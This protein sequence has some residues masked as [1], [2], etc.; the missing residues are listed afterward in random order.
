MMHRP[1]SF[2]RMIGN[3]VER[4]GTLMLF[5]VTVFM[6]ILAQGNLGYL[7]VLLSVPAI[8]AGT[9]ILGR[10]LEKIQSLARDPATGLLQRAGIVAALDG[11][12]LR[13]AL[14]R[15][16]TAVIV[17]EMCDFKAVEERH[18]RAAIEGVFATLGGRLA[19]VLRSTDSVA[20]LDG[21]VFAVALSSVR[22]LD[23]EV[24]I[25][26][27]TRLQQAVSQPIPLGSGNLYMTASVGFCLA[28][29]LDL[30]TGE[31]LLQAATT[32]MIEAER[33]GPGAI[34]G[35]S[36]AMRKRIVSRNSLAAQVSRALD[37]GEIRA[38]FQPQVSTQDG[39]LTGFEALARWEHPDRGFIPP[40][41]F[42]P[43]LEQAGLM[44]RLGEQMVDQSLKALQHWDKIG[45][46]VPQVAVNFS[47]E[48]LQNPLLVDW[49]RAELDR[50]N[51]SPERLTIEVLE[52]VVAGRAEN[53]VVRNL[54][55][56]SEL[57]C[58]L[59]LDDFGTGHA[60]ITNIR[61]FSIARIKIDR[62]FVT[63]IDE[64]PDQQMMF[65]AILT[66]A[67]RLGLDTLAEGVE[68][69]SELAM[70]QDLGCQHV[71]GFGIARPMPLDE[72]DRWLKDRA[73]V[74]NTVTV[75]PR[76]TG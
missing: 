16:T 62:S 73:P 43:A 54:A 59:D 24:A 13:S 74:P 47:T 42:L 20:R 61:R 60:S 55:G 17:L 37:K 44:E 39:R 5:G 18:D 63:R 14:G 7:G 9:R 8:W 53:Q 71:Q 22:R 31:K 51:M 58:T 19:S 57:G 68:N 52:T 28:T 30:P 35:Y 1:V 36:E 4:I 50:Y 67:D 76:R 48:E 11:A 10:R 33:G 27:C 66:M 72:T 21:P 23:L 32:A 41:E 38:F 3:P 15:T 2:S 6:V 64:D 25:Q 65:A 29:R 26:L 75:L 69:D 34:R 46:D 40:I 70:L 56:L 49:I 12:L 45:I